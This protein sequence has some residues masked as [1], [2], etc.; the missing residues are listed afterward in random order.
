MYD[1]FSHIGGEISSHKS[2]LE[3]LEADAKEYKEAHKK[4]TDQLIKVKVFDL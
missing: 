4:Y 2:Q 3:V 1:Q